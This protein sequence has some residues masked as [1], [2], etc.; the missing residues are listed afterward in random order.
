MTPAILWMRHG[1]C[2][3][4]LCRPRAHARPDSPLTI[5]GMVEAELTAHELHRQHWLPTLVVPS[6]LRR[7]QQTA[8]VVAHTLGV[9][10]ADPVDAFAE[11]RAPYCVLGRAPEQY[12]PEYQAW[13]EHRVQQPDLALLGG[14]S[15]HA[16]AERAGEA[17][18]FA[19][20]LAAQH[21]RVLIVSH[22][23]LIGAVAAVSL[24]YRQPADIFTI[25]IDFHLGPARLWAPRQEE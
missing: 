23:L 21:A 18:S 14:D 8:A 5:G 10:P 1:T 15:L 22:R 20:E 19:R 13:R 7:A 9:E 2:G 11:W 12:P 6:P 25:A 4:G 16:F 24:G 3:D 17:L